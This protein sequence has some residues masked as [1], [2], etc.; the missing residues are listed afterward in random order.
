MS[1]GTSLRRL[2]QFLE[3]CEERPPIRVRPGSVSVTESDA[4]AT[5]ELALDGAS[6]SSIRL[7]DADFEDDALALTLDTA[8]ALPTAD[9]VSLALADVTFDSTPT[10]VVT[11]TVPAASAPQAPADDRV[12]SPA[13]VRDPDVP[14]FRDEPYLAALYAR[15]DTF[16]EMAD[17]IEMD[18]ADE[19]VRRYMIK[20]DIHSPDSYGTT[21]DEADAT[22]SAALDAETA[23]AGEDAAPELLADG[24]GLPESVAVDELVDAVN[25]AETVREVGDAL[26][27]ERMDAFE[28]LKDLDLLECVLGCLDATDGREVNRDRIVARLREAAV[29]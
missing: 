25:A 23:V 2:G 1:P 4:R 14:A 8:D 10:A 16:A 15:H 13:D 18:V 22:P 26:G 3:E 11:A 5:I 7:H 29:R 9:D 24:M 27:L 21:S 28:L 6:G 17:A 19:T 20:H 12:A